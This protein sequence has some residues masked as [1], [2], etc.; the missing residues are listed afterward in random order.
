MI[1]TRFMSL[2]RL[3]VWIGILEGLT[4]FPNFAVFAQTDP[5]AMESEGWVYQDLE[6]L[7]SAGLISAYP[8][9]WIR[10]GNLLSRYEIAYYLKQT[11]VQGLDA[12]SPG[13]ISPQ[14]AEALQRLMLRFQEELADLG[15]YAKDIHQVTPNLSSAVI[16]NDS[17]QDLDILLGKVDK[18][19]QP[20]YYLGQYYDEAQRKSFFFIPEIYVQGK[21]TRLLEGPGD[22]LSTLYQPQV[23][24]VSSFLVVKGTL[25]DGRESLKGYYLFPLQGDAVNSFSGNQSANYGLLLSLLNEVNQIGRIDTLWRYDGLMNLDGYL[26]QRLDLQNQI[27]GGTIDQG[28][29]IGSLLIS[30]NNPSNKRNY[31]LNGFG[32]PFKHQFPNMGSS[33]VDLDLL[34]GKSLQAWQ[35][36]IQ[37]SMNLS[38]QASIYGGLDL[39]YR[40]MN[41]GEESVLPSDTKASAGLSYHLNDDWTILSYQSLINSELNPK[42]LSTTSFGVEYNDWVTLWLAYQF[43]KFDDP[44]ITGALSFRF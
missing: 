1:Q 8:S 35:I 18:P 38:P 28:L 5:S 34:E 15:I 14:I 43:L 17:Y 24:D 27:F 4:C 13:V 22:S 42:W 21:V 36:N 40:D 6:L 7:V 44:V 12:S 29:Q 30:T 39:L 31:D 20:F 25:P 11:V 19:G 33:E 2:L 32:L 26:K 37:G 16:P 9:E 10:S 23:G 41:H 3:G